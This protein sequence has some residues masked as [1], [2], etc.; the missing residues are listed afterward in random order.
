MSSI[1]ATIDDHFTSRM[2]RTDALGVAKARPVNPFATRSSHN[3]SSLLVERSL[4][5]EVSALTKV[6]AVYAQ[7]GVFGT[8]DKVVDTKVEQFILFDT[9]NLTHPSSGKQLHT[10]DKLPVHGT[11]EK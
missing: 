10:T 1:E 9:R 2:V 4:V 7:P 3:S 6:G 5:P 8:I 11:R